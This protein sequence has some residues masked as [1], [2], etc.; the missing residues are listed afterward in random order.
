M[1]SCAC[2][3]V[4]L[5]L[6][7]LATAAVLHAAPSARSDDDAFPDDDVDADCPGCARERQRRRL[8][9]DAAAEGDADLVKQMRL[10]IIKQQILDRLGLKRRP[11]ITADRPRPAIPEPLL[12]DMDLVPT[13]HAEDHEEE[14]NTKPTEVI[15]FATPSKFS[16]FLSDFC[17]SLCQSRA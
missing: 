13:D 3:A 2:K 16:F 1:P 10:D 6:L 14:D 4:T 8:E 9:R 17:T 11:N 15:T 12:R 5:L 7:V